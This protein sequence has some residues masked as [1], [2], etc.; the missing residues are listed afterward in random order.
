LN[1]LAAARVCLESPEKKAVYDTSIRTRVSET[2]HVV[3]ASEA[4]PTE[5]TSINGE[6]ADEVLSSRQTPL[7]QQSRTSRR[8][9]SRTH[10][11]RVIGIIGAATVLL[12]VIGLVV[13]MWLEAPEP[14]ASRDV[15]G[16][17][18]Q[19]DQPV[20]GKD[21]TQPVPASSS[22]PLP[23]LEIDFSKG[24]RVTR[25]GLYRFPADPVTAVCEST[26]VDTVVERTNRVGNFSSG[27]SRIR[28]VNAPSLSSVTVSLWVFPTN[29]SNMSGMFSIGRKTGAPGFGLTFYFNTWETSNGSL[30]LEEYRNDNAAGL[31]GTGSGTVKFNSWQHLAFTVDAQKHRAELFRNGKR[32]GEVNDVSFTPFQGPWTIGNFMDDDP[33]HAFLGLMDDIQVFDRALSAEEIGTVFRRTQ[34]KFNRP[35]TTKSPLVTES[36]SPSPASAPFDAAEARQHQQKWSAH[37]GVPVEYTNSI[38]MKLNLIPAGHCQMGYPAIGKV[39]PSVHL[40]GEENRTHSVTLSDPVYAGVYEVTRDQFQMVLSGESDPGDEEKGSHPVTSVSWETAVNFCKQLSKR[41]V[42]KEAARTYRLP[43]EAEWEYM[44][45]AGTATAF[46]FGSDQ[47]ELG[48]YGWYRSNSGGRT[49]PVGQKL[50]NAFGLYDMHGNVWEWCSDWYAVY[51]VEATVDPRG[52]SEGQRRVSRGGGWKHTDGFAMSSNRNQDNLEPEATHVDLGF[53]VVCKIGNP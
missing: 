28:F 19:Q 11:R 1:E 22:L 33:N 43:T 15:A 3:G 5:P 50:P 32:V 18:G 9:R 36:I 23:V 38:G 51:P 40:Y 2:Q 20:A 45:R 53:R 17:T 41:D 16:T 52:P 24:D 49:H 8:R 25:Q 7:R 34:A 12:V 21:N 6:L 39:V 46:S 30:G 10:D 31:V 48:N 47:S 37:L 44:C 42:E 29:R 26:G 14:A 4:I 35:S 13:F 27:A